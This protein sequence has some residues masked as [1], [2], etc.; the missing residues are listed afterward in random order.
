MRPILAL[1]ATLV[2]TCALAQPFPNRAITFV[3][4]FAPGGGTDGVARV[5]AKTVGESMGQQVVV[6][7]KS[8]AGGTIAVD[9]VAKAAPDGYTLVLANVG[10]MAAN[11][12]MMKLGYDP[13]KDLAPL[14][15]ATVFANVILA[16]PQLG[17][18]TVQDLVKR[19][20][21]KPATLTYASSGVGG[22]AHLAGELLE[23]LAKIDL[24]HVPYKGGGPA[25]A[26]FLGNQTDLFIATPV[27]ALPHVSSGRAVAVATTSPKR[28]ALM[29]TVPT[30]A[31]SG[32]QG[33]DASNWYAFYGPK[34]LPKELVERW[35]RELVKALNDAPTVAA[36]AKQ[37]VEAA[38]G[39]PE[40]LARYT[41]AEFRTWGRVVKEAGIKPE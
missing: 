33:F 40:E 13:L 37:G 2:S 27:T 29:P 36:L 31:E 5:I 25:M 4:G 30:V 41:E 12:H 1:L 39:T 7:N 14:T 26:G 34:G 20:K 6:D 35:N 11:P 28:A 38:P 3:V 24:V 18:R 22:A 16:Q 10:A 9:F 23:M 8:G 17:V 21:E 32:F 15:M 19:A